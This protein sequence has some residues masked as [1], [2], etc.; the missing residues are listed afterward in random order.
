MSC[1]AAALGV[2]L[3]VC[4]ARA[5]QLADHKQE[6]SITVWITSDQS[7][8]QG[9]AAIPMLLAQYLPAC[10]L[11]PMISCFHLAHLEL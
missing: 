5:L 4:T 2:V 6:Q 11:V 1:W 3:Q 8:W 9:G 7:T 10:C